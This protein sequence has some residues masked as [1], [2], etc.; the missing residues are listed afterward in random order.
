MKN[1]ILSFFSLHRRIFGLCPC[2]EGIF[3]L[4]DCHVYLKKKPVKDWMDDYESR[5][6][7]LDRWEEKIEEEK[8]ALRER[9]RAIGRKQAAK[10]ISKIDP[11]FTPRRL[12]PDDAKVVFHPIDFV[13]F[14]GMKTKNEIRNILLLDRKDAEQREVQKSIE[15]VVEKGAYEWQ[16]L[17]IENDGGITVE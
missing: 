17:R 9:A 15:K 3:R 8:E 2:C 11:V 13:V 7:K 10:L 5:S 1:D 14:D 12:D 16:T 4:S 6:M